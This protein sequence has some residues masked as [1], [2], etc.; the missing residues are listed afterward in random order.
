VILNLGVGADDRIFVGWVQQR[1]THWSFA[2]DSQ[3]N[4]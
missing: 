4:G 3:P 2:S 1:V